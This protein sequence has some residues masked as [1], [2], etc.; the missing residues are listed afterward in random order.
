M[1]DSLDAIREAERA[2]EIVGAAKCPQTMALR[3][4]ADPTMK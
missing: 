1:Y 3:D 2:E 4:T